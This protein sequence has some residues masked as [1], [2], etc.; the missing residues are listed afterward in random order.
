M[1]VCDGEVEGQHV[2][3]RRVDRHR[4]VHLVH[5]DA[6]EQRA[7]VTDV[8][9]RHTH[10]ADLAARQFGIRV[11]AGLRW[12]V[13]GDRQSRLPLGQ[14][15]AVQRV[16]LHRRRVAGV[17]THQPRLVAIG[18]CREGHRAPRWW[19]D[20]GN[21]IDSTDVLLPVEQVSQSSRRDAGV[22]EAVR[23]AGDRENLTWERFE[24]ACRALAIRIAPDGYRPDVILSIARGRS[25]HGWVRGAVAGQRPRST[26]RCEYVWRR[27]DQWINCPWSD[28]PPVGS[29][30]VNP[31]A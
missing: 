17:G 10:L 21:P 2:H 25:L 23:M 6:L 12:Q 5:R 18:V 3:C 15:S 9:Y 16:G 7:Q 20:G 8:R 19:L 30:A 24:P 26:V 13:E 14:V 27:A 29:G 1:L 22:C 11:V 31:D 4:R 28:D